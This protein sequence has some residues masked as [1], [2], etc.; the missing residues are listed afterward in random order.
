MGDALGQGRRFLSL[1]LLQQHSHQCR[2]KLLIQLKRQP[3][4]H[5]IDHVEGSGFQPPHLQDKLDPRQNLLNAVHQRLSNLGM[6]M[7]VSPD[8][9]SQP[10]DV[11]LELPQLRSENPAEKLHEYGLHGGRPVQKQ[12][13]DLEGVGHEVGDLLLQEHGTEGDQVL[14]RRIHLRWD[15]NLDSSG[16]GLKS[17]VVEQR[18]DRVARDGLHHCGQLLDRRHR[19]TSSPLVQALEY[20]HHT[21]H[22]VLVLGDPSPP[23]HSDLDDGPHRGHQHVLH[24]A[25]LKPRLRPLRRH[26]LHRQQSLD[27]IARVSVDHS[28]GG[29]HVP[30]D[31]R[32]QGACDCRGD[33]ASEHGEELQACCAGQWSGV[34][35]PLQLRGHV[36]LEEVHDGDKIIGDAH[37]PR[38]RRPSRSHR[39]DQE[40]TCVLA[41]LVLVLG[42][43]GLR[44]PSEQGRHLRLVQLG[45]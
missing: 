36:L 25:E 43:Q 31:Q 13:Q 28:M 32:D 26:V 41:S 11:R 2:E 45:Q 37:P 4:K 5:G 40:D 22:A 17:V 38:S 21:P 44:V 3:S 30:A 6:L 39:G 18:I 23:S 24:S 10:R 14:L 16:D 1:Q 35:I 15:R 9:P 12:P 20:S 27:A 33:L 7:E 8:E 42:H 34:H 29:P 19:D